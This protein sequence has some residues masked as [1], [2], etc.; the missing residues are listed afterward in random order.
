MKKLLSGVALTCL[1][2]TFASTASANEPCWP[3]TADNPLKG[4]M[5][6]MSSGGSLAAAF[7]EALFNA[8]EK[9]CGV[10]V[11][12]YTLANRSLDQM[13]TLIESGNFSFDMFTTFN[14]QRYPQL[15]DAGLLE[16]L[17][18]DVWSGLEDIILPDTYSEY[19]IWASPFTTAMI[20]NTEIFPDGINNWE[21]FWDVDTFPGPR[22]LRD[23]PDNVVFALLSTGM[24]NNDVYPITDEKLDLAFEQLNKLRP[25]LRNFWTTGDQPVQG[26]GSGEFVAGTAWNG[27]AAKGLG[28]NMPIGVAWDGNLLT[29]SWWVVPKNAPNARNAFAAMRFIQN[30]ELQAGLANAIGYAGP[31]KGMEKFISKDAYSMLA[32]NS[33]NAAEASIVDAAWWS[34]NEARLTEIWSKWVATGVYER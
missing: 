34:E 6:V 24:A 3:A 16:K 10:D 5:I 13:R 25:H 30:A 11:Q 7:E 18:D 28:Q 20:Y 32:S 12:Q 9:A 21:N 2:L 4:E 8:F 33:D 26:V 17:P 1:A 19:G 29:A 14:G 23:N 31:I 22:I 27:R 15:L